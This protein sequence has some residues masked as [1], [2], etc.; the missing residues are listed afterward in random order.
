MSEAQPGH[1]NRPRI[2]CLCAAWCQ[3]CVGYR[4]VFESVAH[5]L[6]ADGVLLD[7][8]WIDIEDDS[9][10][11]GELDVETFPTLLLYRADGVLFFGTLTPQ[12]PVLERVVREALARSDDAVTIQTDAIGALVKRLRQSEGKHHGSAHLRSPSEL[13]RLR[14]L[15]TALIC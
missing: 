15:D 13:V 14:V 12:A 4:S 7:T 11:I 10:L 3:T 5:R 1:Q 9:D 6:R 2:V 8:R